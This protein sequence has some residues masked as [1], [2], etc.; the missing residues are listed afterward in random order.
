M[1]TT[2]IDK[3]TGD[4]I[5][6]VDWD[7]YLKDNLN[8]GVLRPI[9]GTVLSGAAAS[10]DFT[11]IPATFRHLQ[12]V[13]DGRLS[14]AVASAGVNLRFN[15][16]TGANYDFQYLQSN[17][18][19]VLGGQSLAQTSL[20]NVGSFPGASATAGLSGG[21]ELTI[22]NYA[23]TTWQK[24]LVSRNALRVGT[25]AANYY[26]QVI[27]G[28]WRSAA[29]INQITIISGSGNFEIGTVATLYGLPF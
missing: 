3:V 26:A 8:S 27:S 2:V 29:A 20:A 17:N 23:G 16:D 10:I 7:T 15:G 5:D 4:R 14:G 1:F 12:L 28:F 24:T 21:I 19:T 22:P 11:G 25:A 18:T 6:E 13:I 9:A